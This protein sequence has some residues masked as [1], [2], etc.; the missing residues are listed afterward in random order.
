M[1]DRYKYPIATVGGL[2]IAPDGDIL[3]LSS[4]KWNDCYTPP[5]GKIELGESR[6][7]AFIREVKEETGLDV[8]NIK[9]ITSQDSIFSPDF[10]ESRHFVM[11]DFIADLAPHHSKE[12]VV[13]NDEAEEYLWASPEKAKQLPLN[14]EF[15]HL[16]DLYEQHVNTKKMEGLIGFE[17]LRIDCII[18]VNPEEKVAEQPIYVDLKVGAYFDKCSETDDVDHTFDYV[19]LGQICTE[20]AK[21]GRFQLIEKYA[22]DV[23][24]ELMQRFPLNWAWIKVKKP[25]AM[26]AANFTTVE[27]KLER[28]AV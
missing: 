6:E 12:D 1:S 20:M 14:K 26:P 28:K 7:A 13:L 22:H 9:F 2:V 17:H 10:K 4:K 16:L 3:L 24:K 11:N 19:I 15:Y 23:L 21:A 5:G 8:I 25:L 27:F 18:G